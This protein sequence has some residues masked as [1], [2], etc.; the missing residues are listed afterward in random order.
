MTRWAWAEVSSSAIEHNV[1]ALRQLVAPSQLWAVVKADG[2]GHGSVLAARAAL[3]GGAD[4]LCVALVQEG[5]AL[6]A[7]GIEGPILVLS[8]QP[9]SQT[10]AAIEAGLQLTVYSEVGVQAVADAGA[11]AHPVHLK[12]DTGMRRVGAHTSEALAIA[13]AIE[14]SPATSLAGVLTHL[15][16]ADDPAHD[17]TEQQLDRFDVV[18]GV[19][20]DA[21]IDPPLVHAANSAGAL[22][23]PRARFDMVRAGIA[24]YGISP[25]PGVDHLCTG[26]RPAMQ[27]KARVAHVKRVTGGER[28]SYGLRHAFDRDTTV[29]T[30]PVGYADGVP[31]RLHAV[32]GTVLVGGEPR[33]IVG[34]VTM[35]QTM[36]DCGDDMVD[37][38]DEAVL[39]GSQGDYTITAADWADKLET[40]AYEIVCGVSARMERRPV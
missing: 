16:V 1:R 7:A 6:R 33:P 9:P 13:Q 10:R 25:G 11:R 23:H 26:L 5:L 19:L 22:A 24:I 29:A 20:H 8:E 14:R 31:R 4:G 38:G 32:G 2:Y 35:D 21:G 39:I 34:V 40:I 37:V 18:L 36:V 12:V 17:F 27:L 28:I 15:A 30:L 3:A